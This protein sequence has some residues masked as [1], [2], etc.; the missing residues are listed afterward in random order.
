MYGTTKYH[1]EVRRQAIGNYMNFIEDDEDI[2][3]Y[4]DRMQCPGEWAT[5][6]AIQATVD[7][8]QADILFIPSDENYVE[9]HIVPTNGYSTQTLFLG[10]ISDTHYVSSTSFTTFTPLRYGGESQKQTKRLINTCPPHL[11]F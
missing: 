1:E 11:D 9:S 8:L 3:E 6:A 10:H 4:L 7:A 5:N 2:I